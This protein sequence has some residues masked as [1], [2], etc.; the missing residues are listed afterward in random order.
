ML[1]IGDWVLGI[2]DWGL[3]IKAIRNLGEDVPLSYMPEFLD[4]ES[5]KILFKFYL[6]KIIL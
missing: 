4:S 1:G 6:F 3:G 5:I 2:G